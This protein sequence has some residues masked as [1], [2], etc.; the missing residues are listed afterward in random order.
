MKPD[1]KESY[2]GGGFTI[3]QLLIE[4]VTGKTFSQAMDELVLQP[5]GMRNS[6]FSLKIPPEKKWNMA[7]GYRKGGEA[8][9]GGYHIHPEQA[10]AG[11][12]T[13]P[14]DLAQFLITVSDCYRGTSTTNLL[15]QTTVKEML[16]KIPGGGGLG[17]GID[18]KTDSLRFRHSGGN[19]GYSCYAISF[20]EVGRG[21]VI[22]TNSD[23]GTTLIRELL[24]SIS[25]EYKWPPMWPRE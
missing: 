10:A 22:M 24:R 12:W 2:S 3:L 25:R 14:T 7:T 21:A 15:P 16:K 23:N 19:D 20:A 9:D 8:V 1:T 11:L 6:K 5:V 4:E 13:T 17:F 18:G